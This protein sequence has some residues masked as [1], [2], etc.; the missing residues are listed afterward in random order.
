MKR[1]GEGRDYKMGKSWI[2]NFVFPPVRLDETFEVSFE[3]D[4]I[5][6]YFLIYLN[7]RLR[8]Y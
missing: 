1:T 5:I 8:A 7:N 2:L 6:L 4:I 3:Y